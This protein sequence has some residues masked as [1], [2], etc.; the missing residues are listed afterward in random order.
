LPTPPFMFTT[1]TVRG[2]KDQLQQTETTRAKLE[3]SS[4]SGTRSS[5]G[6]PSYC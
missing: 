4:G 6:M 2:V 1:E 5:E 3:A